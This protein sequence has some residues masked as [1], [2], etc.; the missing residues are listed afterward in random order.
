MPS[1]PS[2]GA[3]STTPPGSGSDLDLMHP[4]PFPPQRVLDA[5]E[6]AAVRSAKS[7]QHSV[8]PV[9]LLSAAAVYVR[10]LLQR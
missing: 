5:M 3:A 1:W 10:W 6:A 8:F 7:A 2:A 4:L 9:D